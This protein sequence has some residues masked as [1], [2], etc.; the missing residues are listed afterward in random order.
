[1]SSTPS[2]PRGAGAA[3]ALVDS[4]VVFVVKICQAKEATKICLPEE[5]SEIVIEAVTD[6]C[7]QRLKPSHK[8]LFEQAASTVAPV[9]NALNTVATVGVYMG[10]VGQCDGEIA[11]MGLDLSFFRILRNTIVVKTG[12]DLI[13]LFAREVQ[14]SPVL[15]T[16]GADD[17]NADSSED[18]DSDEVSSDDDLGDD[19]DDVAD[20]AA[21]RPRSD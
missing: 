4:G 13:E 18:E 3:P 15:S 11:D 20:R 9:G 2:S 16:D 6:V 17:V 21:K 7:G 12:T 5:A 8:M 19:S 1:M 10:R 14:I